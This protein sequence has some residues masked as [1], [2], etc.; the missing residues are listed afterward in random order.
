MEKTWQIIHSLPEFVGLMKVVCADNPKS[1]GENDVIC[2]NKR[3]KEIGSC[4]MES[5]FELT[6]LN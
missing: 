6:Q 3:D 4:F 5:N 1:C 2:I